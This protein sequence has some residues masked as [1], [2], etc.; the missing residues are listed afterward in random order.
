MDF[1]GDGVVDVQD[2]ADIQKKVVKKSITMQ[3]I[4]IL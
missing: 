4:F 3:I 2:V 1:N